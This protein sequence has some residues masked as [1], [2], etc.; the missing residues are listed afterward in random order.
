MKIEVKKINMYT[1]KRTL[2][3]YTVLWDSNLARKIIDDAIMT[4]KSLYDMESFEG[5][6]DVIY[7]HMCVYNI[8]AEMLNFKKWEEL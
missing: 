4:K 3:K 2:E 5:L 7:S 1:F 6:E 8:F